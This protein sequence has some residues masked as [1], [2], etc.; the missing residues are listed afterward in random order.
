ML[1]H[2]VLHA[3]LEARYADR[4]REVR[5]ELQ[6]AGFRKELVIAN[7][8]TLRKIV[9]RLRVE[10]IERRLERLRH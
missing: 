3:K 7:A 8:K 1:T 6:K 4:T 10:R 2:V 5:N 9:G